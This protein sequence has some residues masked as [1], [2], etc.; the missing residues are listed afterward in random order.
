MVINLQDWG[1]HEYYGPLFIGQAYDENQVI[2][3]TMSQW[4]TI[5]TINTIGAGQMNMYDLDAS[6]TA[7]K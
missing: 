5:N 1:D 6:E 3:D 4:T 7:I 2:Y